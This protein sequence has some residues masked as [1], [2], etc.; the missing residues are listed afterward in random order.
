M[1]QNHIKVIKPSSKIFF[2]E[3][4]LEVEFEGGY[5]YAEDWANAFYEIS[6]LNL[7]YNSENIIIHFCDSGAHG[8]RFSDY[9]NNNEQENLL[10]QA[11]DYCSNKKFKIIG[12]LYNQYAR[13]SFIECRKIYKGYYNLVDLTYVNLKEDNFPKIIEE[14]IEKALLN[15]KNENII[16]N[17]STIDGFENDFTFGKYK[18]EMKKLKYLKNGV[19]KKKYTFLPDLDGSKSKEINKYLMNSSYALIYAWLTGK[20]DF[21]EQFNYFLPTGIEQGNIGDCYLISAIL[22]ILY[23]NMPLV[24]YIFPEYDYNEETEIIQ[25][26]VYEKGIRKLISFKNTYAIDKNNNNFIFGNPLNDAFF[27]ICLEKGY[28]VENSDKKSIIS[29][30]N[31]IDDGGVQYQVFNK[32]F[33]TISEFYDFRRNLDNRENI[34]TKESLKNKIKKYIKFNGLV[35]FAV[36]FNLGGAH[37]FSVIDCK[38]RSDDIF[39]IEILNPWHCCKKYLKN[40]IMK[41]QEYNELGENDKMIFD[42]QSRGKNIYE[43][44][45][46]DFELKNHFEKYGKTGY[47]QMKYDTFYKWIGIIS[48][49]DPMVGCFEKI[50]EII[51]KEERHI[52]YFRVIERTKLKAFLINNLERNE[53]FKTNGEWE[54]CKYKIIIKDKY[55]NIYNNEVNEDFKMNYIY[56]ILEVG[57]Y[58]IEVIP[59]FSDLND[60]IYLK[61]QTS[62]PLEYSDNKFMFDLLYSENP[63]SRKEDL[64]N[65]EI[66]LFLGCKCRPEKICS[67]CQNSMICDMNNF[68]REKV[69]DNILNLFNY[70]SINRG[71]DFSDI[72]PEPK[73]TYYSSTHIS[74][75]SFLY[76]HYINTL[77]GFIVIIVNKCNFNWN[78]N[79]RIEYRTTNKDEFRAYFEFGSFSINK[80]LMIYNFDSKFTQLLHSFQYYSSSLYLNQVDNYFGMYK[81]MNNKLISKSL[82]INNKNTEIINYKN[83]NLEVNVL[84]PKNNFLDME[85]LPEPFD[86]YNIEQFQRQEIISAK[87]YQLDMEDLPG[88]FGSYNIKQ[89]ESQTIIT[90]N[91]YNNYQLD[92]EDLPETFDSYNIKQFEQQTINTTNNNYQLDME[93][94]PETF[95]SYNIQNFKIP[96]IINLDNERG[97]TQKLGIS[98]IN[99]YNNNSINNIK[100]SEEIKAKNIININNYSVNID[101]S[102]DP[103]DKIL[104]NLENSKINFVNI[105][106]SSCYQSSTLQGFVHVIFPKAIRNYNKKRKQNNLNQFDNLD[107]FKNNNEFNNLVVDILKGINDIQENGNKNEQKGFKHQNYSKNIHLKKEVMKA[108]ETSL[109]VIYY[110]TIY[111]VTLYQVI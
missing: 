26:F 61:I 5:D 106:Y 98:P 20:A 31:K 11:L 73:I 96:T 19:F 74:K 54:T 108:Q 43:E 91:N 85:D 102:I 33:G 8:H 97:S 52:I 27:N 10:I 35:T 105:G 38:E 86:S 6:N 100:I 15:E 30:F 48:F 65:Y 21:Y 57:E 87:N 34:I 95:G 41:N 24:K 92:M 47:L 83:E 29:G 44:E 40:N 70:L 66:K 42:R 51:Q 4:S 89:I 109:I 103:L 107:K 76:F 58:S 7:D 82:E 3:D 68:L 62:L 2:I 32:L 22:S 46:D 14:N 90:T 17:Y 80:S 36:F 101:K 84:E 23:N 63:E 104:K 111:K 59:N 25:M 60:Y 64:R 81:S 37:A 49:C 28:A 88:T 77:N 78:C 53:S 93:D 55:N 69:M 45:F 72:L 94:L 71:Y 18:C 16:D 56:E 79:S 1:N 75:K 39:L 99:K 67:N 110:M 13:K 50:Y 9:D 12:L